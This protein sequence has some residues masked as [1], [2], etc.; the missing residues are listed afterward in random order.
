[1]KRERVPCGWCGR[2]FFPSDK[3]RQRARAGK[4]GG[5]VCG[6]CRRP[7]IAPR[8]YRRVNSRGRRPVLVIVP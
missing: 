4:G 8:R 6:D 3:A 5:P 7:A 2:P 1:M